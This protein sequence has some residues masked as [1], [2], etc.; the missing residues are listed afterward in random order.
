LFDHSITTPFTVVHGLAA[1]WQLHVDESG[2]RLNEI[3]SKILDLFLVTII[4]EI[5]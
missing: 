5:K 2:G 3:T 1:L 4:A